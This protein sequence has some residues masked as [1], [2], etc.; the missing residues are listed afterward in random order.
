[1]HKLCLADLARGDYLN[2]CRREFHV[3]M[4]SLFGQCPLPRCRNEAGMLE[5]LCLWQRGHAN[6]N[7]VSCTTPAQPSPLR[8]PCQR[9]DT[10]KH[11]S[12]LNARPETKGGQTGVTHGER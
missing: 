5:A 6:S 1:M 9:L 7:H 2:D 11:L 4:L 3:K 10:N 8:G 12:V